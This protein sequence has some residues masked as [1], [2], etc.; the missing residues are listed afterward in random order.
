LST[1]TIV[2]NHDKILCCLPP[3]REKDGKWRLPCADGVT[4]LNAARANISN[5]NS[6]PE[7]RLAAEMSTYF[8]VMFQE[9]SRTNADVIYKIEHAEGK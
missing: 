5:N 8:S 4:R 7:A 2:D 9:P 6:T 3:I 1:N